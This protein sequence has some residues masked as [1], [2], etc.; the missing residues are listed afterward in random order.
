MADIVTAEPYVFAIE[1]AVRVARVFAMAD[2]K[3]MSSNYIVIYKSLVVYDVHIA[4][5]TINDML[6]C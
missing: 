3:P 5:L 4:M 1:N 6:K 2:D